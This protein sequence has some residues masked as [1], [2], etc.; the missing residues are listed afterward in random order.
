MPARKPHPTTAVAGDQKPPVDPRYA[1]AVRRGLD[2]HLRDA[3]RDLERLA[4]E[5]R[6]PNTGA[7]SLYQAA[8]AAR[9]TGDREGHH[10]LLARLQREHPAHWLALRT[11]VPAPAFRPTSV[12]HSGGG[13]K[14]GGSDCG[15]RALAWMLRK[16]G[17]PVDLARLTRECGTT[18]KGTTLL[19]LREA[20]R[21]YGLQAEGA[22]VRGEFLRRERPR[23]IAWVSGI[24]YVC[25]EPEGEKA[26]VWDPNEKTASTENWEALAERSQ[27]VVLL[28]AW[29]EERVPGL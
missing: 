22:Q 4:R 15:P 16:A 12:R 9:K 6:D 27:G 2:G 3:R 29:G 18:A 25:F 10:E 20:A 13:G 14:S 17:K 24:H 11:K 23:G 7:W 21:K 1:A 26:R 5:S 8:L 19:K 28:L